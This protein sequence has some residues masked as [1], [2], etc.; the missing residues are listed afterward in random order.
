L[1]CVRDLEQGRCWDRGKEGIKMSASRKLKI[2]SG[3]MKFEILGRIF[4]SRIVISKNPIPQMAISQN[5][6]SQIVIPRNPISQISISLMACTQF[7]VKIKFYRKTGLKVENFVMTNF[8]DFLE[9]R[10]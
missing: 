6:I 7:T 1:K 10:P 9:N 5:P 3:L 8:C 4:I 2:N